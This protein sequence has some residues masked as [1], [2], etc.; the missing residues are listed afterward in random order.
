[1]RSEHDERRDVR[2]GRGPIDH[3]VWSHTGPK[4]QGHAP[5]Q[6]EVVNPERTTLRY[7][8]RQQDDGD[9]GSCVRCSTPA[10]VAALLRAQRH[11]PPQPHRAKR[12]HRRIRL[13][14]QHPSPAEGQLRHRLSD[15]NLDRLPGRGCVASHERRPLPTAVCRLAGRFLRAEPHQSRL[16][17]RPCPPDTARDHQR[18]LLLTRSLTRPSA[19]AVR[20]RLLFQ[21]RRRSNDK[22]W[23]LLYIDQRDVPIGAAR[24]RARR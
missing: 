13:L 22:L 21:H 6:N 24:S 23:G 17:E 10:L 20:L 14:A 8:R 11:R 2:A 18:D 7:R 16:S 15:P 19:T 5:A 9:C 3:D 4:S 12:R 1:M